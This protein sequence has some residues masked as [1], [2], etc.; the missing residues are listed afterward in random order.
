MT[1][2]VKAKFKKNVIFLQAKF[3]LYRHSR[4]NSAIWFTSTYLSDSR[5]NTV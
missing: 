2:V 4:V 1:F 5:H 3:K